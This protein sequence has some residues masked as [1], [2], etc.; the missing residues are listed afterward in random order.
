MTTATQAKNEDRSAPQEKKVE[1]FYDLI[2]GIE[3]AMLTTRLGDG[4]LVSRPMATQKR[5]EGVDLWFVTSTET[6]KVEEIERE[7][8]I[9]LG[10]YK[11][12]EWVSVS[13]RATLVRDRALIRQL[14]QPDWRAW[15]GDEGGE[16]DGGPDD[17][18]LVLIVVKV[19]SATYFKRTQSRPVMWLNVMKSVITGDPPD[20]GEVGHLKGSELHSSKR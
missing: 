7:P 4:A 6:H 13:G 11:D 18:R 10:Y 12:A 19:E 9:N 14:Y 20:I 15:F 3:I 1:D 2:D 5:R 16:R 8:H 17:P